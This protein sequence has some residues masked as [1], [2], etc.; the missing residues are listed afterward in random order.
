MEI[1]LENLQSQYD[2]LNENYTILQ[3]KYNQCLQH[4][5]EIVQQNRSLQNLELR[6]KII[7]FMKEMSSQD[8]RGTAF[9]YYYCIA[10]DKPNYIPNS[11]GDFIYDPDSAEMYSLE[12]FY[13]HRTGE[14]DNFEYIDAEEWIEENASDLDRYEQ[15]FEEVHKNF[16]LTESDAKEHL[17]RNRYHY[18]K[19][20]RTYVEY[21][22]RAN[23]TEQFFVDLFDFFGVKIPPKMYYENKDKAGA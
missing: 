19:N 20:A 21:M 6:T 2:D 13:T 8:N 14:E 15:Q 12:E 5:D 16:F 11:C 9:P 22:F 23:K 18:G 3:T 4:N 1:T 7:E 10:Y 17:E